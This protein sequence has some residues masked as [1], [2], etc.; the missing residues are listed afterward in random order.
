MH[1]ATIRVITK[2]TIND[3]NHFVPLAHDTFEDHYGLLSLIATKLLAL[4]HTLPSVFGLALQHGGV[5][6]GT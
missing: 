1:D 6:E 2:D 4:P 3:L 5:G